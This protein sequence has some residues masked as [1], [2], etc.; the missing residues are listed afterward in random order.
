[1]SMIPPE[2]SLSPV[3]SFVE[4][5]SLFE[6][7]SISTPSQ[8]VPIAV[9]AETIENL[10]EE[11]WYGNIGQ[12]AVFEYRAVEIP[13]EIAKLCPNRNL[14]EFECRSIGITQSKGWVNHWRNSCERN[15]LLFRRPLKHVSEEVVN[16]AIRAEISKALA[17]IHAIL[18]SS[19]FES[20]RDFII[21]PMTAFDSPEGTAGLGQTLEITSAGQLAEWQ[22]FVLVKAREHLTPSTVN[23]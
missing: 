22:R 20:L 13:F 2:L 4:L 21:F 15:V 16:E 11:F 3:F 1:M 14:T 12:D 5:S 23:N 7:L 6:P 10:R 18:A 9:P 17:C 8:S 19:E